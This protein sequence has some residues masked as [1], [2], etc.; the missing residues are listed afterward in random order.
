MLRPTPHHVLFLYPFV[1]E[2]FLLCIFV[3]WNLLVVETFVLCI[4]CLGTFFVFV[5][6]MADG[7]GEVSTSAVTGF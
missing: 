6:K 5:K 3:Y 4:C 2:T 1:F 7:W